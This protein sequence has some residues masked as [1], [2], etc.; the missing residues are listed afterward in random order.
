MIFNKLN[1]H[2]HLRLSGVCKRWNDLVQNDVLFMR[3]VSFNAKSMDG[4]HTVMRAYKHVKLG[5]FRRNN[6]L[7]T[8]E[9]LLKLLE[10]VEI[11]DFCRTNCF[12]IN[13]VMRMCTEN[14]TEIRLSRIKNTKQAFTFECTWPVTISMSVACMEF[15]DRFNNIKNISRLGLS[16]HDNI[17]QY[18]NVN[19]Q[20]LR[21]YGRPVSQ[22][23]QAEKDIVHAFFEKQAHSL[24]AIEV[25]RIDLFFFNAMRM[26][27]IN[28]ET[29]KLTAYQSYELDFSNLKVLPKL[30]CLDITLVHSIGLDFY[31]LDVGELTTLAELSI[32]FKFDNYQY[33]A[34]APKLQLLSPKRPMNEMM[35][36]EMSNLNVDNELLGRVVQIMPRLKALNMG[37]WVRKVFL[38]R[39]CRLIDF[40][41]KIFFA[42][43]S[44]YSHLH[45][46]LSIF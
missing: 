10:N 31:C 27:L 44:V 38:Y 34:E 35:K 32:N 43:Q 18:E 23:T 2:G 30:K 26:M 40:I 39:E 21:L 6:E 46:W 17:S 41:Q 14:V 25:E 29:V 37:T 5:C 19:P 8:D 28:L 22:K 42:L 3:T 36:F 1:F 9:N 33:R 16:Y 11:I 12:T 20:F 24:K 15:L 7:I 4:R 45:L 13:R